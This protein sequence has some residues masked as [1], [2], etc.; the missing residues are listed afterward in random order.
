MRVNHPVTDREVMM[1]P[2]TILVTRTNLKGIITYANEAFIEISGFSRDELIG[3]N[4]NV[5]RH[6]DMPPAAFEDMWNTLKSGRPWT[7]PVKNRTKSGDYYWVEANVTPVYKNAKVHEYLSV[8]YAPSR[9]QIAQAESLYQKLN[10]NKATM[11]PTGL[12]ALIMR[13]HDLGLWKKIGLTYL[14]LSLPILNEIYEALRLQDYLHAAVYALVTLLATTIGYRVIQDIVKTLDRGINVCYR[15]ADE[16]FRNK[17]NLDRNDEIG[18]FLR[19]LY[20]TQVKLNADLAFSKQLAADTLRIKQ[21]LDNVDSC[22]MVANNELDIIY[23]N[24]TVQAMFQEAESDIRQDLPN[25]TAR[26]LLGSNI[27]QFHKNPSHQRGLLASLNTT[28]SS[29]LVVGGRHM[30]IVA[31]PVKNEHD[32]RIGIVVEWRDRTR[33]VKVENEIQGIVQSVKLGQLDKRLTLAGKQGFF[34]TLSE[35]IN[36]LADVI[37]RVFKDIGSTMECMAEGDLTNRITS[38]YEGVYLSCKNDINT[39]IDKLNEIFGQV[40]E[41][42]NFINNSSQEIASG[43]NNLS[44]RAEQQA[45]NLEQTA[46]S[47]EQ[48]TSTVKNNADNAQQANQLANNARE[49]AEKGG[50]VVTAAVSAMRE[51]N[52]SSNKI[53]DI[54]GVIDEIAFQTNLLALNASVEAARAGEQGR[55]FS[56][57]ATEVRNLA[58]RSATAARESK[59]LIQSSVQKVRTGTEFVNE[60]GKA[61][62]EIV[63]GVKRVGDI[64]AEIASASAEQSAGIGQV[65]QAVAQMDEIT[66]QN[67]ALAEEASAA[68]VSMSDLST[69]MVDLL[70]FFK[71]ENDTKP[72]AQGHSIQRAVESNKMVAA[73][74]KPSRA[75][76]SSSTNYTSSSDDEWQ[77]F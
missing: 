20:C 17:L 29:Q 64:V 76:R 6:P 43:N 48:L 66:Q 16:Q 1:K 65:N 12:A 50:G 13:I 75:G 24:N 52:E 62:S 10:A 26:N 5:V 49:L 40:V 77:D 7:A 59:E 19:A 60:T 37:E 45:A 9:E 73:N 11:R 61:L 30:T 56:V 58:Q 3:V 18:E 36:E 69:S 35:G 38:D 32:E 22:V 53:A 2:G 44:Q 33:E 25:F 4:H 42:A 47:M 71:I 28:F 74:I 15:M 54:I 23:L 14:L 70:S 39:T 21:A 72:A 8:R 27:D 46:A 51:I 31:N 67:A 63:A 57:V 34:A 55:G 68:S 41:S